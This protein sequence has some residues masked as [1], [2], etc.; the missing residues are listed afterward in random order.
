MLGKLAIGFIFASL[1][2]W[3]L[4]AEV[5][6]CAAEWPPFVVKEEGKK[7]ASGITVDVMRSALAKVGHRL[8]FEVRPYARCLR[9][10]HSGDFDGMSDVA[11][12]PD[13]LVSQMPVSVWVNAIWVNQDSPLKTFD[14]LDSFKDKTIGLVRGYQYA[15]K[16][17][18]YEG[19]T[20]DWANSD[21]LNIVKLSKGRVQY[22]VSDII[23]T[24]YYLKNFDPKKGRPK[25]RPLDPPIQTQLEYVLFNNERTSL[26]KDFDAGMKIVTDD[27]TIDRIYKKAL[28]KSFTAMLR[29]ALN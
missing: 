7:E 12:R 24:N 14:G 26:L 28:N 25:I 13:Y 8:T 9:E 27:G 16:V 23:S 17:Q 6:I 21:E 3:T 11:P 2:S 10:V 1:S 4:A 15:P 5:K 20:K 18:K 22:I 19:W 29:E